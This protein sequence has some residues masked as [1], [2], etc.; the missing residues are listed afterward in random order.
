MPRPIEYP[1]PDLSRFMSRRIRLPAPTRQ[2]LEME[3]DA[4]MI[5][6]VNVTKQP[7]R[8]GVSAATY[9]MSTAQNSIDVLMNLPPAT[10]ASINTTMNLNQ[11]WDGK[12]TVYAVLPLQKL[13]DGHWFVD[14]VAF[15]VN[16]NAAEKQQA[17]RQHLLDEAKLRNME[18]FDKRKFFFPAEEHVKK[19]GQ[20]LQRGDIVVSHLLK[21]AYEHAKEDAEMLKNPETPLSMALDMGG[22][23]AGSLTEAEHPLF[24]TV[25]GRTWKNTEKTIEELNGDE[26]LFY[27]EYNMPDIVG[28]ERAAR[29]TRMNEFREHIWQANDTR[30]AV[31]SLRDRESGTGDRILKA[32]FN[33][34]GLLPGGGFIKL[35]GGMLFEIAIASDVSRVTKLRS[36]CYIYFVAGFIFQLTLANTGTPRWK[37]DRKYFDLGANAAPPM[38]SFDHFAVQLSLLHYASEHYTGGGWY[39]FG[40]V[41]QVWH[42]PETYIRKWSPELLGYSLTTQLHTNHYLYDD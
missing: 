5:D 9:L 38:K 16:M 22:M 23:A 15:G 32:G 21:L 29:A 13:P 19:W 28:D 3:L 42:I 14:R 24:D 6:V 40:F 33:A 20:Y 2:S 18:Y 30:E 7:P 4:W 10:I 17:I 1:Q 31:D 25:T 26:R 11:K 27:E 34:T 12:T 8:R 36:R 41:P 37:L 39:G 35:A